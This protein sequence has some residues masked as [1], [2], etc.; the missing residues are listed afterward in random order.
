MVISRDQNEGRKHGIKIH[1]RSFE[2]EE[3][4]KY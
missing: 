4:I 1:Y 3:D 2:K